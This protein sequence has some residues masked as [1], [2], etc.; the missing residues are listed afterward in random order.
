MCARGPRQL[1][2]RF[3]QG[4][5]LGANARSKHKP[6]LWASSYASDLKNNTPGCKGIK[7]YKHRFL[8][9]VIALIHGGALR[10]AP[11]SFGILPEFCQNP[12]VALAAHKG[13]TTKLRFYC[14]PRRKLPAAVARVKPSTHERLTGLSASSL[15]GKPNGESST[16][17]EQVAPVLSLHSQNAAGALLY[18]SPMQNNLE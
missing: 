15:F 9:T 5:A 17:F 8:L 18:A 10:R 4:T 6:A 16:L 2:K 7:L 3:S 12:V 11:P 1:A 13:H 14:G